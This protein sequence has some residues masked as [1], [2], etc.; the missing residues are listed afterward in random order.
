MERAVRTLS[1]CLLLVGCGER[2]VN[3]TAKRLGHTSEA[4]GN[5]LYVFGGGREATIERATVNADGSL[6]QFAVL[7]ELLLSVDRMTHTSAVIGDYVY[8][9]GGATGS[10]ASSTSIDRAAINPDHSLGAFGIVQ[11]VTLA[12]PRVAHASAV[13]GNYVYVLGGAPNGSSVLDSV[14]RATINSDGSLGPFSIVPGVTLKSGRRNFTATALGMNLYIFGG[15]G[16][17]GQL[18][19]IERS[20]IGVDGSLGA[21]ETLTDVK[22]ASAGLGHAFVDTKDH[23]YITGG[24]QGPPG[25]IKTVAASA[26]ATDGSLGAFVSSANS[27]TSAR[28]S[29][30]ATVIGDY[31]YVIGGAGDGAAILTSVERARINAD[32]T[33][34]AFENLSE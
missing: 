5:Y 8:L 11:N 15:S 33:L 31:V 12:T 17:S 14:E 6:E 13:I 25:P 27:L 34:A 21:F 30:S 32:G 2:S 28:A 19:T 9:F 29:H 26:V 3:L 4:I 24:I 22:L 10:A 20:T 1:L 23:L 18:D 7:S 16:A